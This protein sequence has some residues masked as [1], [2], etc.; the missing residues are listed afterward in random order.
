MFGALWER[1][2]NEI[3]QSIVWLGGRG[4]STMAVMGGTF[5]QE[6]LAGS[7]ASSSATSTIAPY[8]ALPVTLV[9]SSISNQIKHNEEEVALLKDARR[10]IAATLG[11]DPHEVGRE[12][13]Y[14]VAEGIPSRNIPPNETLKEALHANDARRNIAWGASIIS[15]AVTLAGLSLLQGAVS[16]T[17]PVFA[18]MT[19]VGAANFVTQYALKYAGEAI[20]GVEKNTTYENIKGIKRALAHGDDISPEQ[21]LG[22]FA[23]RHPAISRSIKEGF[24]KS[25]DHL[26]MQEQQAAVNM[27]EGQY[28]LKAMAEAL[29][30]RSIRPS[31]LFFLAEGRTSGALQERAK[32]IERYASLLEQSVHEHGR[33][34][35]RAH[36]YNAAV[37]LAGAVADQA[38]QA[39][40]VQDIAHHQHPHPQE[41]AQQPAALPSAPMQQQPNWVQRVGV[42]PN[43][44][45]SWVDRSQVAAHTPVMHTLG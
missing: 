32:R 14:Q 41:S 24:G 26:D 11:L 44:Q 33:E 6:Y 38:H 4:A 37:G 39:H 3:K 28:H 2:S 10:E 17:M 25:F 23:A 9:A 21:V 43:S 31:E 34:H 20:M 12:H 18:L 36:L 16:A 1:F 45:A 15:A 30:D 42:A 35:E 40:Q 8:I 22:V 13:L 29:S 7:G 5:A 27:Y 19:M